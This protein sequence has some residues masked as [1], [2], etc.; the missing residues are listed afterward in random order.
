MV[1]LAAI[2]FFLL[3]LVTA[4]GLL[5]RTVRQSRG[6]VVHA[7]S[8]TGEG[9]RPGV[10]AYGPALLLAEARRLNRA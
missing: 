10:S 3:A 7:L 9:A 4:V 8:D 1:H 5:W 6:A 2:A